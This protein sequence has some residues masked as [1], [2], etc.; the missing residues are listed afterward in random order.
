M[1]I[2]VA[3]PDGFFHET[4]TNRRPCNKPDVY[5]VDLNRNHSFM[6]NYSTTYSPVP[7]EPCGVAISPGPYAESEPETV[8]IMDVVNNDTSS[9]TSD[10]TGDFETVVVMNVHTSGA[11]VTTSP[12]VDSQLDRCTL[13]HNLDRSNCTQPDQ[14]IFHD[15]F[16][17]Q[18]PGRS[19]FEIEHVI[20]SLGIRL[21]FSSG[22]Q[23][24]AYPYAI[25]GGLISS[26]QNG[27]LKTELGGAIGAL[28]EFRSKRVGCMRGDV[29]VTPPDEIDAMVDDLY[30]AVTRSMVAAPKLIRRTYLRDRLGRDTSFPH[31]HR[32]HYDLEHPVFRININESHLFAYIRT[33]NGSAIDLMPDVTEPG[34][35]YRTWY[36]DRGAQA[37]SYEFPPELEVCSGI[38]P[39]LTTCSVVTSQMPGSN[40]CDHSAW[41]RLNSS[42]EFLALYSTSPLEQ[43][44]WEL[45]SGYDELTTTDIDLAQTNTARLIFSYRSQTQLNTRTPFMIVEISD[46]GFVNCSEDEGTG[47]RVIEDYANLGDARFN[48]SPNSFRTETFDISYL[49]A[50]SNI[51]IQLKG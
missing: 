46:N 47:C 28:V 17:T 27:N 10:L 42:W 41:T 21:P 9:V 12:G 23:G 35:E 43:C 20:A 8:A 2:P 26:V 14:A 34:V 36:W 6:W 48:F 40:L 24:R 38:S 39:E 44:Y 15:L 3:N 16:G 29:N 31:M 4:R 13:S 33:P 25:Y 11:N 37:S 50:K 18:R 7:I 30:E 51:K 5:G 32:V 49:E 22:T 19:V 1:F 45:L